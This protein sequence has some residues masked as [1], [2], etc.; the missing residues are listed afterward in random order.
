MDA[1]TDDT[2]IRAAPIFIAVIA[3]VVGAAQVGM[4]FVIRYRLTRDRLEIR[5]FGLRVVTHR[6]EGILA[7]KHSWRWLVIPRSL[8]VAFAMRAGNR[9]WSR[10]FVL[11]RGRRM[12]P[13]IITP[14]DPDAFLA[15][16]SARR[17]VLGHEREPSR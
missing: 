9:L 1:G 14:D 15:E 16:L 17:A 6:L 4:R 11:I 3:V 2:L 10:E 7:E 13:V 5:M 8:A 12:W